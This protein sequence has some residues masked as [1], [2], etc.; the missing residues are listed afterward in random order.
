MSL[1]LSNLLGHLSRIRSDIPVKLVWNALEGQGVKSTPDVT[2]SL[3][4]GGI[5]EKIEFQIF[6]TRNEFPTIPEVGQIMTVEGKKMKV[7]G[8][9]TSPDNNNLVSLQMAFARIK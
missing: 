9:R 8:V 5:D 4:I 7:V 3:E 2:Q 6:I 1:P